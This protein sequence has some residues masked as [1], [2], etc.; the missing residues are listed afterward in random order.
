[1]T[2]K[3]AR[4][5]ARKKLETAWTSQKGKGAMPEK[6]HRAGLR[7]GASFRIM[8][9]PGCNRFSKCVTKCTFRRFI[10]AKRP[11]TAAT[12]KSGGLKNFQSE[13]NLLKTFST[14]ECMCA[15][16]FGCYYVF[17]C[18]RPSSIVHVCLRFILCETITTCPREMP[19]KLIPACFQR[20]RLSAF[21]QILSRWRTVLLTY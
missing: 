3:G 17:D 16:V 18:A 20:A 15:N 12:F 1:M 13:H 21:S 4:I 8:N 10:V 14:R 7:I 6:G 11:W 19:S 2:K 5:L 9:A